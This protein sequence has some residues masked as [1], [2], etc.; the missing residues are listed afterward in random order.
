MR[1]SAAGLN[2][3]TLG[4]QLLLERQP[5]GAVDGVRRV[6]AL[7]AQEAASPY[8]AL[9]NRLAGF[10]PAGLDAAFASH[11]VLKATLM[12]I[13]LHAVAA[14]DHPELHN[15]MQGTLRAARLGD[16][17]FQQ[18]GLTVPDAEALVPELLEFAATPRTNAEFDAL[19]EA[20][21][22]ELPRPGVWW[23]LRTFGSFVHAPTGGPWSFGRRPA[24]L[25]APTTP[26]TRTREESLRHLVRRYLSGFGPASVADVAQFAL[27]PRLTVRQVLR[28]LGDEL[29]RLEGPGGAELY[30]L[31]GGLLPPEDTPAPPRLMA[32]WDSVLL[33]YADR[34]RVIPTEYRPLIIRRNG[35][36]LPTLLVDGH[37]AGVWRATDGGI[38]ATAFHDLPAATWDALAE[39]AKSLTTFLTG[40]DPAVYSRYHYWWTQLPPGDTHLLPA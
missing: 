17:R 40:R 27:V 15:A 24:Y 31:P 35:D 39:E 30:D 37:V 19:L 23:A 6:V 14:E 9:W 34:A 2:R 33:A 4:R 16:R 8:L 5:L 3:A 13:T 28:D 32:M 18:C 1:I 7:Q 20:R 10:E 29:V 26:S 12:R 21:F 11:A 36:T 25:A 22:G 38:E